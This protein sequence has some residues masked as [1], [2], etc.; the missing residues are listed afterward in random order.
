MKVPKPKTYGTLENEEYF[1]IF[2]R[3][4]TKLHVPG[5]QTSLI[6]KTTA[7]YPSEP[8]AEQHVQK[9]PAVTRQPD[10]SVSHR[11]WLFFCRQVLFS[12]LR[13][14]G[15]QH[16]R[17]PANPCPLRQQHHPTVS[18]CRLLLLLPSILCS[19]RV[20]SNESALCT[21]WPKYWS[22]SFSISP[23]SE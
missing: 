23:S 12:S 22:S 11:L 18:P 5:G 8:A 15:L 17:L 14:H 3:W 19:T 1:P 2:L 4:C 21:R 9:L 20:F 16:A 6:R 13:C 7:A 10:P